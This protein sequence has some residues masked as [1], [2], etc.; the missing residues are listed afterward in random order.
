MKITKELKDLIY[1][2]LQEKETE[3]R[4]QLDA[5][6][7]EIVQKMNE[8]LVASDE[9][10]ALKA[11]AEAWDTLVNS[12]AEANETIVG[13]NTSN[14]TGYH[15]PRVAWFMGDLLKADAV[16][17]FYVK[18]DGNLRLKYIDQQD[19]IILRL[20]YGKDFEE[21]KAILAEYGITI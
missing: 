8:T 10:K 16:E 6:R 1:R 14:S 18:G 13:K 3:E 12:V 19:T 21:A 15:S 20:S 5:E 2:K 4:R 11:A 7:R 17:P 9:F